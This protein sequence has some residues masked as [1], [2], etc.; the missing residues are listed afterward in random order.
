MNKGNPVHQT[1]P[2]RS[3]KGGSGKDAGDTLF[4]QRP[5]NPDEAWSF[6][7]STDDPGYPIFY[8]CYENFWNLT[9]PIGD[10]HWWI[11]PLICCWSPCDPTGM[12]FE[13]IFYSD[14]PYN[15]TD[16]PPTD[17]T[18]TYSNVVPTF[19]WY[20]NYSGYDAYFCSVNLDPA[21]ELQNG[22]VSIQ[23]TSS[24][25]GCWSLLS[26]S[27]DGDYF[28]YQEGSGPLAEDLAMIL[29]EGAPAC[30]FTVAPDA[31]TVPPGGHT[32]LTLTFDGSVFDTCASDTLVCYLVFTSNDCD[33]S[34]VTV[35]VYMWSG[36]GDVNL[37]CEINVEDVVFLLNYWFAKGGPAPA[38]LCIADVNRDGDVDSYDCLYLI[39][40]LFDFGPP[41][42]IPQTK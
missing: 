2:S 32:D 24:P 33:E 8:R 35:P 14:D 19:E 3:P 10:I 23:S 39:S 7:T 15:T 37:D 31:G 26:G 42:E 20:N 30:P 36:R 4:Y 28:A 1:V 22:W 17:V 13:I 21:C 16:M 29:T 5:W 11:L 6:Y 41:P 34:Q 38:P 12:E 18:L 40:Y 25:N 27:P 9:A